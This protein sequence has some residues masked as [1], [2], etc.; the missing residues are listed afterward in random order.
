MTYYHVVY[1]GPASYVEEDTSSFDHAVHLCL[2]EAHTRLYDEGILTFGDVPS[3]DVWAFMGF[4]HWMA[5]RPVGFVHC[6]FQET[7]YIIVPH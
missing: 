7:R 2:S 6:D 4:W 5:T 1:D 3:W